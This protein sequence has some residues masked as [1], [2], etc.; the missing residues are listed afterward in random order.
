MSSSPPNYELLSQQIFP[1]N[2]YSNDSG[3]HLE[4]YQKA[5]KQKAYK[6]KFK[7]KI[8]ISKK[9]HYIPK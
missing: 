6:K 3:G 2:S 1:Q 7:T 5:Q 4:D 9:C 8:F